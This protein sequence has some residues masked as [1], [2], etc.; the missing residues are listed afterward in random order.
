MAASEM[1]SGRPNRHIGWRFSKKL[2]NLLLWEPCINDIDE[3]SSYADT[4]P[5]RTYI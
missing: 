1:S 3:L 5:K 4:V 2:R